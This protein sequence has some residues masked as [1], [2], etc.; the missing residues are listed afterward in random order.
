MADRL[1]AMRGPGETYSDAILRI[2]VQKK[3]T[4]KSDTVFDL[5]ID[6]RG[7]YCPAFLIASR[8]I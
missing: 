5:H 7:L 6:C 2:A 4:G 1:G 3:E 8:L